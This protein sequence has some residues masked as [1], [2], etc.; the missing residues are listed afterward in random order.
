[1]ILNQQGEMVFVGELEDAEIKLE[2]MLSE[3]H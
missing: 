1:M 2:S 3:Q